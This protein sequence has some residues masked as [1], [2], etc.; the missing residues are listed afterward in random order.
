MEKGLA[1]NIIL[2]MQV[3]KTILAVKLHLLAKIIPKFQQL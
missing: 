3:F 2:K 1:K